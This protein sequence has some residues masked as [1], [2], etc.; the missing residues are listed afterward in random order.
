MGEGRDRIQWGEYSFLHSFSEMSSP[1]VISLGNRLWAMISPE[2]WS[3][4]KKGLVPLLSSS[5]STS[6]GVCIVCVYVC[7]CLYV[8]GHTCMS[9]CSHVSACV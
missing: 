8:W 3:P 2:G 6:F 7:A 4:H 5:F 1:R 9:M